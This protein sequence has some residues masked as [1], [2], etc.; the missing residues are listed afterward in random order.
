MRHPD[1]PAPLRETL[2]WWFVAALIG[3]V[4][5]LLAPLT[6]ARA[7]PAGESGWPGGGLADPLKYARTLHTWRL[8]LSGADI[9]RLPASQLQQAHNDC[10]LSIVRQLDRLLHRPAL[11]QAVVRADLDTLFALGPRGVT[12]DRLAQG[13]NALGWRAVVVRPAPARLREHPPLHPPQ[14]ALVRPGHFVLVTGQTS[15]HVEYFDPLVGQVR[16]PRRRFAAGWTG[17]AVQLSTR[18]N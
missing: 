18:D 14:I 10:A 4:L 15:T 11:R 8:Q 16:Q 2:R 17:K 1:V 3:V 12:L 13:L 9:V 7:T 6:S 5:V